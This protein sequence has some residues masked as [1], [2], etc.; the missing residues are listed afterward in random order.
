MGGVWG[1]K[2]KSG[3]T[4]DKDGWRRRKKKRRILCRFSVTGGSSLLAAEAGAFE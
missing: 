4:N 3:T 2:D 1:G